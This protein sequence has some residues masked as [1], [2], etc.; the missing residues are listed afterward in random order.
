MGDSE[1]QSLLK[2]EDTSMYTSASTGVG[3]VGGTTNAAVAQGDVGVAGQ[4]QPSQPP[5][6][7]GKFIKL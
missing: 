4:Q 5:P 1:R 3:V 6:T 7:E 2:N